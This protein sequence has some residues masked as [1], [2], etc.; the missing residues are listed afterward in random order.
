MAK[1]DHRR[2]QVRTTETDVVLAVMV[3]R[4]YHVWMNCG[5]PVE[6]ARSIAISQLMK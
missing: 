3:A 5:L 4:H 6:R 1:H 2:I